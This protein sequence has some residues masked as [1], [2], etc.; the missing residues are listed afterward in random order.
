MSVDDTKMAVHSKRFTSTSILIIY[1]LN[2][3]ILFVEAHI[4]YST[5]LL[6]ICLIENGVFMAKVGKMRKS[7]SKL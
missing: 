5:S 4:K 7:V 6:S 1:F 3:L 2:V